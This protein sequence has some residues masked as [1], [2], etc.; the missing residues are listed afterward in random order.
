MRTVPVTRWTK[1]KRFDAHFS[2]VT[3]DWIED[4][5]ADAELNEY[6]FDQIRPTELA[7]KIKPRIRP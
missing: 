6:G 1:C 7:N 2:K 5:D 4:I 3:Q